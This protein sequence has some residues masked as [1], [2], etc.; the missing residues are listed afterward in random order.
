MKRYFQDVYIAIRNKSGDIY[1]HNTSLSQVFQPIAEL[2]D[3]EDAKVKKVGHESLDIDIEKNE[4]K[5]EVSKNEE[6]LNEEEV[7]GD[8]NEEED[9]EEDEEEA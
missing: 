6:L 7:V 5:V 2:M 8:K 4:E 1:L 3:I 9:L